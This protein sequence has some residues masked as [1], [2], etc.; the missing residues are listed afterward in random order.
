MALAED[1]ARRASLIADHRHLA[2]YYAMIRPQGWGRVRAVPGLRE[3]WVTYDLAPL[4]WTALADGGASLAG[5]LFAAG[6]E[7]VGPAV[8]GHPGWRSPAEA[9]AWAASGAGRE[10]AAL[11]TIHIFSSLPMGERADLP[12]DSRGRFK[13]LDNLIVA[14]ASVLPTAPGVNPQA[15][16]MALALRAADGF[17]QTHP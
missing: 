3:P 15:T 1:W 6:A 16:I 12:V 8:N 9:K 17:L 4:D 10:R 13:A 11:M 5:A 2:M 14:D 7:W